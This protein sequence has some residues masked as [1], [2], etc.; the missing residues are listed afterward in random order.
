MKYYALKD[1]D[2]FLGVNNIH[3]YT[4]DFRCHISSENDFVLHYDNLDDADMARLNIII[5]AQAL[6]DWAKSLRPVP[7]SMT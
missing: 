3:Q 2:N 1:G 4:S 6:L 5:F 7:W